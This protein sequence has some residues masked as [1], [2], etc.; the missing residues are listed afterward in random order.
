MIDKRESFIPDE[1]LVVFYVK[2]HSKS[3][4]ATWPRMYGGLGGI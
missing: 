2:K 1:E 3:T 4:A